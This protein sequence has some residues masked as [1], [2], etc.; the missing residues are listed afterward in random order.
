MIAPGDTLRAALMVGVE[1]E[2]TSA[3]YVPANFS[4]FDLATRGSDSAVAVAVAVAGRIGDRPAL[5][6]E[7]DE[8][9]LATILH[10]TRT[11]ELSWDSWENFAAFVRHKDAARVLDAHRARGLPEAAGVREGYTRFAKSLVAVGDAAGDDRAWGLATEIVALENPYTGK[12][13]DGLDVAVLY[14]GAPR[15]D[16]QVEI[17]A[18]APGGAVEITT[19]ETDAEGVATIPVAPGVEY[20]LDA[21]VIREP[22]ENLVAAFGAEWESLWASLTF[23]VPE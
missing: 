10:V 1:F 20:L 6:V 4:R 15:A 18:R 7:I 9:G 8:P 19:A 17:F 23:R 3:A 13:E 11:Y 12:T 14:E 5:Q 22:A 16:A 21:V 2:G